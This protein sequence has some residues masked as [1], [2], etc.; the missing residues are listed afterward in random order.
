[1]WKSVLLGS[2]LF[3]IFKV[4]C[5]GGFLA[6]FLFCF[7]FSP[8]IGIAHPETLTR[9]IKDSASFLHAHLFSLTRENSFVAT[10]EV[11]LLLDVALKLMGGK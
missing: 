6:L 5:F 3:C 4:V 8:R 10:G 7:S 1:M 2:L 9:R 11:P